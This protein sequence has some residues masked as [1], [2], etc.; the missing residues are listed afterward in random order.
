MSGFGAAEHTNGYTNLPNNF[1]LCHPGFI[2]Q[3]IVKEHVTTQTA[4]V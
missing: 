4:W 3:K 2:S 1:P